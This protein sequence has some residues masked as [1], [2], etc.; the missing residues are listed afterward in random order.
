MK[1]MKGNY[2]KLQSENNALNKKCNT[3]L[4]KSLEVEATLG[5]R[6]GALKVRL[7]QAENGM[8][9]AETKTG[10]IKS[11]L[12]NCKIELGFAVKERQKTESTHSRMIQ[13][14]QST[15]VFNN[16][17]NSQSNKRRNNAGAA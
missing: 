1:S 8:K 11:T 15:D 5:Q 9:L 6:I 7:T 17:K 16:Q 13:K 10:L 14:V 3:N 4:R 2:N 12:D